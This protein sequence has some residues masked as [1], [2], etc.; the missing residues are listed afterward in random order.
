MKRERNAERGLPANPRVLVV[1]MS[2]LGDHFHALPV[3]HNIKAEIGGTFDWVTQPEY[4]ELV[5]C[6]DDVSRVVAFPRRSF[7]SGV[8]AFRR[9]LREQAYDCVID[10]QGLLKSAMVARMARAPRRIG[11]S[12]AR[13]GAHLLY[14]ETAGSRDK[15]R[16][17]VEEAMDVI[18]HL[19]L[20]VR[21]PAFPVSFPASPREESSPRIAILPCSRW[22]TKN[23]SPVK[24]GLV[25]RE[26]QKQAKASLFLVGSPADTGVC[27]AIEEACDDG[28]VNLCGKTSLV[29]LGGLLREMDLVISV[30]SGPM[31]MAAAVGVPVLAVFG[32]TDPRRTGPF[33]GRHCVLKTGD[34]ECRPCFSDKCARGDLA[35]LERIEV[36]TVLREALDMLEGTRG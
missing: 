26:L 36:E 1:K 15:S 12:Y 21:E 5:K 6:F 35:C 24:F 30:D 17:A 27:G 2:S 33:G 13:E 19:G 28:V 29:E 10:L 32:A 34:L 7:L 11:P 3:V 9:A 18:R 4:V 8:A 20:P 31:H 23:W 16:H 22:E 14:S 25:A